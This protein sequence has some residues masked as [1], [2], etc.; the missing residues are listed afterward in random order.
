MTGG[1]WLSASDDW[2]L[3]DSEILKAIAGVH[4][5]YYLG[6]RAGKASKYAVLDIDAGSRYHS[7]DGISKIT[8]LL[9]KAGISEY[10]PPLLIFRRMASI[11]IFRFS[12][13][14]QRPVQAVP[15][16]LQTS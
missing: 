6:T 15:P 4:P 11:H 9:D 8:A 13:E 10:N 14:F 5:K 3:T 7:K 12:S 2:K 1:G 16:A